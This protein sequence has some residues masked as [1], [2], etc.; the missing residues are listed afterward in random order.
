MKRLSLSLAAIA[1][2]S[3][4][5]CAIRPAEMARP[6]SLTTASATPITGIG[7]GERGSFAIGQNSGQFE[8][9]AQELSFFGLFNM[10]D[11][12]VNFSLQGADFAQGLQAAC[13]MRERSVTIDIVEFKPAPMALGCDLRLA[14]Q[15]APAVL[16]IQEAAPDF[17]NRQ[18]RRCVVMIDGVRLDI[19]SVHDMDGGI[20]PAAQPLGYVFERDGVAIGGVDINGGPA[21]IETA[22]L[23]PADHKAIML[24]SVALSVFWDPANL[25]I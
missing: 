9:S 8:R 17:T 3:A 2:L 11:G 23:T 25:E 6:A 21:M 20:L 19:R 15:P 4:S 12:G 18:Q 7:G 1:A 24:A 13:T 10:K 16:E 5:A 14:G 22:G